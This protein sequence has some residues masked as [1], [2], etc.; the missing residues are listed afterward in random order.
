M[1][2]SSTEKFGHRT[3][4]NR[5][6]LALNKNY[7]HETDYRRN[8]IPS[9]LISSIIHEMQE[10]ADGTLSCISIFANDDSFAKGMISTDILFII[11]YSKYKLSIMRQNLCSL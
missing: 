6:L 4:Q 10:N 5:S 9:G 2:L 7:C 8:G 11:S 1:S 3:N